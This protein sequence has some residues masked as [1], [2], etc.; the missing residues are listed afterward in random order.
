MVYNPSAEG[1]I[2]EL[3]PNEVKKALEITSFGGFGCTESCKKN[4]EK[5]KWEY[6]FYRR[7]GWC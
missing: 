5:R 2:G 7:Y 4:D 6:L 3:N 1:P